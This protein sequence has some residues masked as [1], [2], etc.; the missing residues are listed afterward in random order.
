M[1]ESD[2]RLDVTAS[3]VGFRDRGV[4]AEDLFHPNE[5]GHA[6]WA[7]AARPGLRDLLDRATDPTHDDGGRGDG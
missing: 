7:E 4:F 5:H 3:N 2:A 1:P 6:L